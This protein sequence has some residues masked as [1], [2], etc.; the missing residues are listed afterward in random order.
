MKRI[1]DKFMLILFVYCAI[2]NATSLYCYAEIPFKLINSDEVINLIWYFV[3]FIVFSFASLFY[4]EKIY[5][6]EK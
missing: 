3:M 1:I 6:G 2:S 4:F 5:K